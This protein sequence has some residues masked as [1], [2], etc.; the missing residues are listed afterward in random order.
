LGIA[1]EALDAAF[2]LPVGAVSDPITTD[3]GTVVFKVLERMDVTPTE[4][5]ANVDR[6]RQEQIANKRNRFFSAYMVRARE[7]MKIELNREAVQRALGS[8]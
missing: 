4:W 1:P 7:K 2:T 8:A 6:F 3:T 5:A